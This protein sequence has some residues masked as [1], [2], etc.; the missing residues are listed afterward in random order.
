[1]C[2]TGVIQSLYKHSHSCPK[3][4]PIPPAR[5]N[6]PT[7]GESVRGNMNELTFKHLPGTNLA[8]ASTGRGQS[9]TI[10]FRYHPDPNR[11]PLIKFPAKPDETIQVIPDTHIILL[12]GQQLTNELYR[13]IKSWS[14]INRTTLANY[15]NQPI[16]G[17]SYQKLKA[18][19]EEHGHY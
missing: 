17:N 8:M 5:I 9:K 15:Y 14:G 13:Q 4:R 18:Y 2:N 7:A 6:P 11:P 10:F 19:I 16:S 1:M 12:G 3:P